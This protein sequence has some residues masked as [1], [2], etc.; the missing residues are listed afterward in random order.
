MIEA[1]EPAHEIVGDP[2]LGPQMLAKHIHLQTLELTIALR[3]EA[4]ELQHQPGIMR[5]DR[6]GDLIP[7]GI[8][9][10]PVARRPVL[11]ESIQRAELAS[12]VYLKKALAAFTV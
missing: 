1:I 7:G 10:A 5:A 2:D 9:L 8:G 3:D 4:L 11:V 12:K 6:D